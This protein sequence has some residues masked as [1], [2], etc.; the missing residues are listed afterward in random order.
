MSYKVI[1]HHNSIYME[2]LKHE[3]GV[4]M[5]RLLN[6]LS[7]YHHRYGTWMWGLNKL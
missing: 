1:L 2:Q 6:P 4:A 7:H 3:C 5:V